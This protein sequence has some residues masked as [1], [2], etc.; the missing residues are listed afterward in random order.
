MSVYAAWFERVAKMR[1]HD[2]QAELA[3]DAECRDRTI[4]IP[5]GF[6]KTAGTMLAWLFHRVERNDRAWPTRL[7]F[8][9][10][11][12]VLV[13]QTERSIKAWL[14]AAG[15]GDVP[16]FVL[17]GGREEARWVDHLDHP[18]ILVGTQ[19]MLL[20]RALNRGYGSARGLWPME[21]GLL[22][23]DAL[24]VIDEVQLMDVGLATSAQLRAFR[25]ADDRR[26]KCAVGPARTWWMSATLQPSWLA[27]IDHAPILKERALP[28]SRISSSARSGGL[29]EVEK[30][31]E[32]AASTNSPDELA[33][34]TI[35]QHQPGS[36]TLVITN[37]VDR[38]VKTF[39]ELEK[40]TKKAKRAIELRLVHSR[41]R[42]AERE[43][44]SFLRRDACG[45]GVERIIVATQVV[46]AGVDISARTLVT[47]LAPW[48]SLVQR[49]GR[50]ARYAGEQ[51]HVTVV[52]ATP[53]DERKAAPYAKSELEAAHEALE[54]LT[55][56]GADVG[57][58][59]LETA[60]EA[61][62]DGE[63]SFVD[64][65]FP[66]EP[67]HVLRRSDFEDLFDTSPDLSGTDLDVSRFI[68]S[69]EERDVRVFWRAMEGAGRE[70]PTD[71]LGPA[72]RE[73]C[74]VPVAE[75]NDWLKK[76]DGRT[77]YALDYLSGRWT[78][79][80]RG[81]PG[82]TLAL[83]ASDGGYDPR[84]G[85]DPS[86]KAAVSPVTLEAEPAIS[87]ATSSASSDDDGLSIA[88]WKTIGTHGRETAE[89]A[90]ELAER[91]GLPQ[92]I[93]RVLRLAG[94]WHDVGKVHAHFQD[95]IRQEVRAAENHPIAQRRDLAKAPNKAWRKPNPYPKRPG[96]RHELASTL[97]LFE[98]LWRTKPDHGALAGAHRELLEVMGE[99]PAVPSEAQRM[100]DHALGRELAALSPDDFDLL[101][102]L[103]CSH[104]GKVRTSWTSTPQ[105]QEMAHGG[106][107]GIVEGD[108][109]PALNLVDERGSHAEL[110]ELSLS[111]ELAS[112]GIGR[113]FGTSWGERVSKL[114]A[115]FGPTQLAMLEAVFRIA[116]WRASALTTEDDR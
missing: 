20:S 63:P 93:T 18:A 90:V 68:R 75:L 51:G 108:E 78:R 94:L 100:P 29:W 67:R 32:R 95:A 8:C 42:G 37:T 57:P 12:R 98:T 111:L 44:W 6:G 47:D 66:Y 45:E 48:S 104:H 114:R 46:E 40:Q 13:E 23:H 72:R 69:G 92:S 31:L 33:A 103:V 97:A 35:A 61:W 36:V 116:D 87:L 64:R 85:W 70:L 91:L 76:K 105:D 15:H 22:H 43:A 80:T 52:G 59:S 62:F 2:W 88:G 65:L 54:R 113:K 16:V 58:R 109:L 25:D 26:D 77:A 41:F 74:P 38:A 83:D 4:R 24:W 9:L 106:I 115:R 27:T 56:D 99:R 17:L 84:V 107:H 101:V 3:D 39:A 10:P 71:V 73:L 102:W 89:I 34:L 28:S 19:D 81:I 49:F 7:V 50:C 96:F 30:Q 60:E 14:E 21:M 53:S 112:M 82:M 110:P 1:P 55:R 79:V 5:T 11:M 86:S